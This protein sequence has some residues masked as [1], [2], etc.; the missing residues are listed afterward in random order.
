VPGSIALDALTGAETPVESQYRWSDAER[1]DIGQRV[2]LET[3]VA[4][5]FR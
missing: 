3:E 5:G 2:E 4:R 1:D